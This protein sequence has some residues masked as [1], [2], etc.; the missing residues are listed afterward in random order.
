[1][2]R[3]VYVHFLFGIK[4]I[5]YIL[6]STIHLL[7]ILGCCP[8]KNISVFRPY[9]FHLTHLSWSFVIHKIEN[10]RQCRIFMIF[11]NQGITILARILNHRTGGPLAT[12]ADG[13]ISPLQSHLTG[14]LID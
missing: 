9:R 7:F 5:N 13:L 4:T 11:G 3:I 6:D 2:G 8:K 14:K 12:A 10:R 1:M